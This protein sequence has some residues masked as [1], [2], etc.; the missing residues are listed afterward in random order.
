MNRLGKLQVIALPLMALIL[1]LGATA[2]LAA[3]LLSI[4]PGD[5]APWIAEVLTDKPAY[6][7]GETITV[8]VNVDSGRPDFV[9]IFVH[10]MEP[11]G[12][13]TWDVDGRYN[14][15]VDGAAVDYLTFRLDVPAAGPQ[16]QW[17]V[18]VRIRDSSTYR[19]YDEEFVLAWVPAA[20]EPSAT[21]TP[22]NTPST[23]PGYRH[24]LPLI[25]ISSAG[26]EPTATA[27][28]TPSQ[29]ATQT[30]T[31]T[32]TATATATPTST[33]TPT[34]VPTWPPLETPTAMP[35]ASETPTPTATATATD[36]ATPTATATATPTETATA[37]PTP[38]A[39]ATDT[40]T[41]T[42]TATATTT[43]TSTPTDTATPTGTPTATATPTTPAGPVL[44]IPGQLPA[45]PSSSVQVPLAFAGNGFSISTL[46]FSLDYTE[47][48]LDFAPTDSDG[49]GIP[50]AVTLNLPAGFDASV[51]FDPTDTDGEL[52]FFIADIFPP[53]SA[54][55]DGVLAQITL[56]TGA[57]PA[58]TE[59]FI[60]FSQDPPASFG[61]TTGQ[62][63]PGFTEDGSV[64]IGGS[65]P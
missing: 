50:D 26:P 22:T 19:Q 30:A 24:W 61:A 21:P 36:T 15:P 6:T 59:A 14:Y 57:A 35:T 28:A 48:W 56:L 3:P 37:T 1:L 7:Y 4:D 47:I 17:R 5:T 39:T 53:L 9:D 58:G 16:G 45:D 41:A 52:D 13:Y 12:G 55:P 40:S 27:S 51:T 20:P 18:R 44:S 54:L 32:P 11:T 64:L 8:E 60:G 42:P 65:P 34:G 49:D 31:G 10:L 33:A 63:V 38:T 46:I 62:S 29:T 25:L 23:E 2:A 43:P